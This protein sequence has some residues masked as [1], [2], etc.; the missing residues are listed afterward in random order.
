LNKII[1]KWLY[2]V[3]LLI[4]I[5]FISSSVL[6][7]EVE[8]LYSAPDI[9]IIPGEDITITE[10]TYID[11]YNPHD[12][13]VNTISFSKNSVKIFVP[14]T[15]SG[16]EGNGGAEANIH[17]NFKYRYD[18]GEY[19]SSDLVRYTL[20]YSINLY[21][22]DLESSSNII[23]KNCEFWPPPPLCSCRHLTGYN[24][25]VLSIQKTEIID[26]TV[27]WGE[28]RNIYF[29]NSLY[30]EGFGFYVQCNHYIRPDR[31]FSPC[32]AEITINSLTI[33]FLNDNT[34]PNAP[35]ADFTFSPS[36]GVAPLCVTF[37]DV[38]SGDITS[39]NWDFDNNGIIDSTDRNPTNVYTE[40]GVYSV[41]LVVT[42]PNGEDDELI[43][44]CISVIENC[45]ITATSGI[46]GTISPNGTVQV[47]TSQD[48]T[49]T[50]TPD[51]GYTI[52][53][54]LV[55]GVSQGL[56]S[57]YTFLNVDEDHT[58][59]AVFTD[60]NSHT[61]K[62][63]LDKSYCNDL[64]EKLTITVIDEDKNQ[65]IFYVE[66]LHVTVRSY[67]REDASTDPMHTLDVTLLETDWNTGIFEREVSFNQGEIPVIVSLN[68]TGILTA[69]YIDEIDADRNQNVPITKGAPYIF[70]GALSGR[71]F[72]HNFSQKDSYLTAASGADVWVI[73]E[74]SSTAVHYTKTDNT[75]HFKFENVVSGPYTVEVS[76]EE[77]P[78]YYSPVIE[79]QDAYVFGGVETYLLFP[80]DYLKKSREAIKKD[81]AQDLKE[82]ESN[83]KKVQ[84]Q[85]R[86]IQNLNPSQYISLVNYLKKM[87][88]LLV[89]NTKI[90][91][92][93][94]TPD[95]AGLILGNLPPMD[96]VEGAIRIF[97]YT[98]ARITQHI[99]DIIQ[100]PPSSAY[101]TLTFPEYQY[102]SEIEAAKE[103][104]NA[105]N[106]F[107]VNYIN[108]IEDLD[109]KLA[110]EEAML[111]SFEKYQGALNAGDIDYAYIQIL[112][113]NA[114]ATF[115]VQKEQDIQADIQN[116]KSEFTSLN[117]TIGSD[118]VEYQQNLTEN[119][120][121]EDEI[122]IL[123]DNGLNSTQIDEFSVLLK[124]FSIP[125]LMDYFSALE[126]LSVH[127]EN[128]YFELKEE[129]ESILQY[130]SMDRREMQ[131]YPG[132]NFIA[133]PKALS[134]GNQTFS[135]F[136]NVSMEESPIYRYDTENSTWDMC[137]NE[138]VIS[139]LV[140]YWIY[141][142]DHVTVD[143]NYRAPGP[144]NPEVIPLFKGWNAIGIGSSCPQ[145][146]HSVFSGIKEN[147]VSLLVY[148]N[149]LQMYRQPI[150]KS[151]EI[152]FLHPLKGH[153]IYMRGEGTLIG[154]A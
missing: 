88:P 57:S 66:P 145:P 130:L 4:L 122:E 135:I 108:L 121:T 3:V 115:L 32:W 18:L 103:S 21:S 87:T 41:K 30:G 26:E 37:S 58:I 1:D 91:S 53:D 113:V 94:L 85:M 128:A 147:W 20:S 98:H 146:V 12:Q 131:L 123:R 134:F 75:G 133:V 116:I 64:F 141:S 22:S 70:Y 59:E 82:I 36:Y 33:D 112:Q 77:S 127:R 96:P 138:T 136:Q 120:F 50:I 10:C 25:G 125:G 7:S 110:T 106:L 81:A 46:G 104:L 149:A 23:F 55:D 16:F 48:Q 69:T 114:Y 100:D 105:S 47:P 45:I 124:G 154:F 24:S 102:E 76:Y 15:T 151:E 119:G 6:A 52:Q 35:N 78:Y 39:W 5:Y 27:T 111:I 143:L 60:E 144:F 54:V 65:D 74:G 34:P 137:S 142:S 71:V 118:L 51:E 107:E 28:F 29:K 13:Q 132:W 8:V 84:E 148:D 42:G 17:T 72:R 56:I 97:D 139:P 150:V 73:P 68:H 67:D 93:L 140:G 129:T 90:A 89:S 61:G 126:Q 80:H 2:C 92:I 117:V 14:H 44:N 101:M 9:E 99:R 43:I 11:L 95:T 63:F 49:F 40:P 83:W 153:W 31:P 38:S 109:Q 86:Y 79:D 152:Q 62:I 19:D